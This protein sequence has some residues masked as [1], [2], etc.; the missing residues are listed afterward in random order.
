MKKALISLALTLAT[1]V[2]VP[3]A[4]AANESIGLSLAAEPGAGSLYREVHRPV[5]ASLTV[6]VSNPPSETKITPLKVANVTFPG[7]MDFFP[8]EKKTPACPDSKL[9]EQSNLA[10]GILGVVAL[11][12]RSVVGVGTAVVQINQ[13]KGPSPIPTVTD[14]KL[15]V[16]NAGRNGQGRPRVLIY[17]YSKLVG[18]G[19][20]MRGTLATNG[21]LRIEIGV[22]PYDSSI[23]QFT[24]G[25]P[26]EPI[27]VD[28]GTG[29]TATIKGL[30]P[31]Y[32]RAKCST[33]TWRATGSFVLGTREHPS[34]KPISEDFFLSSNPFELP[35]EGQAGK[36]KLK[37]KRIS[38]P[39]K[40]KP[41]K[42]LAYRLAITNAGTATARS[43]RLAAKGAASGRAQTGSLAPGKSRQVVIRAKASGRK[44]TGQV[45]F[46]LSGAGFP[47]VNGTRR[48][49]VSR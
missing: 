14:P 40:V 26:G 8:D 2:A 47:A 12:P 9:N 35:C 22:L 19:L 17:G 48:L 29:E 6:T 21:E 27:E 42:R 30:D 38:G 36:P 34:G 49:V 4:D 41:G 16:F 31:G 10:A 11:C 25:I 20:L 33:G 37:I 44:Q 1:L 18:V 28:E 46:A 3:A 7:D 23:S 45:K 13:N 15:V 5:N 32:L 24:M 39:K 43:I